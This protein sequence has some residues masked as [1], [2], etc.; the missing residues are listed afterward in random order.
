MNKNFLSGLAIGGVLAA[1]IVAGF[2]LVQSGIVTLNLGSGKTEKTVEKE[3]SEASFASDL[4]D[5]SQVEQNFTGVRAF[6]ADIAK[7]DGGVYAFELL[8]RAPLPPN[9]DLHLL[10]HAVGDELYKQQKFEGMK[11]CTHDFRNA[12]SH[13]IVVG[14]LLENGLKVFDEVNDVCKLAPGGPGAYT[15]CFHGFGHGVLA[16][17][18]YEVPEAVA[19]CKKVG[20]QEF[21]FEEESQCIGGIVM[22]MFGGINDPA[23]WEAKKDKYLSVDDPLKMCKA[24]YMPENAKV[25]CYS[26]VTPFIFESAGA[27]NGMPTPNIYPKAFAYCDDIEDEI[28]RKSCYGGLGKE[29]IVLSQDR[30][31]RRIE[32]TPDDKLKLTASWCGLAGK[33]EAK[34]SCLLAVV[35]SLYWGGENDPIVSIRYCS[36]LDKGPLQKACFEHLFEITTYYQPD[37]S[38]RKVM[39]DS[40]PA[41]YVDVCKQTLL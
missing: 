30:D 5:L 26:Y 20:T 28:H 17:T 31:I 18:D 22:E 19:L 6:F 29:F 39:C 27:V 36:L 23:T 3:F 25:L 9:T 35:D 13:S 38:K 15:M 14:A 16:F 37:T 34:I 33:Q 24:D 32:D 41:S 12:C 1:T 10:G 7:K 11:Y 40:V 21:N 4:K 8:K 2:Y